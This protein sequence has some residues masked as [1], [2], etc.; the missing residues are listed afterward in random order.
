MGVKMRAKWNF[1]DVLTLMVEKE[2]ILSIVKMKK[3]FLP[4]DKKKKE[5]FVRLLTIGLDCT[6]NEEQY[7]L[8][9]DESIES[10]VL[11][12]SKT[13]ENNPR[14]III[15]SNSITGFVVDKKKLT[16]HLKQKKITMLMNKKHAK[17]ITSSLMSFVHGHF[18]WFE[19]EIDPET[20][21]EEEDENDDETTELKSSEKILN[22]GDNSK[23]G[24]VDSLL[25]P[26][27]ELLNEE[28]LRD[29]GYLEEELQVDLPERLSLNNISTVLSS[30]GSA[31]TSSD[32]PLNQEPERN[33]ETIDNKMNDI[34][35]FLSEKDKKKVQTNERTPLI[36]E[37]RSNKKLCGCC[38]IS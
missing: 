13:K 20:R 26:D 4:K 35:P 3:L 30:A 38:I 11:N 17:I 6:H 16:L 7:L 8:Y 23:G 2:S 33:N 24:K 28:L 15:R 31:Q 18:K 34:S 10:F 14:S 1:I 36:N 9:Y 22:N 37:S 27:E 29:D 12:P 32:I 21:E 19:I 25:K 5:A